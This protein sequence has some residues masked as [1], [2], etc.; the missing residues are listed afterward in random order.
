MNTDKIVPSTLQG[1]VLR[2]FKNGFD[3]S[4]EAVAGAGKTTMFLLLARANANIS[5]LLL[6]YNSKLRKETRDKA[7]LW[8]LN[9]IKVHTYHSF[10]KA[11][12]VASGYTDKS[13]RVAVDNDTPN[14]RPIKFDA[15]LLDEQQDCIEL[16][17]MLTCKVMRDNKSDPRVVVCGDPRQCIYQFKGADARFLTLG[18]N[19]YHRSDRN[20]IKCTLDLSHRIPNTH[21]QFVDMCMLDGRGEIRSNNKGPKP[22]YIVCNPLNVQH[23][24]LLIIQD[25]V[26]CGYGYEDI[27][28]LA[29]S[30]KKTSPV[31]LLENLLVSNL[32]PCYSP[33]NEDRE[34]SDT[35]MVNK[36][37]FS[38]FHQAK[39]RERKCV[40]V[41]GFDAYYFQFYARENDPRTCP[42]T[43]Y[44][45]ATRA[46][47]DM[48]LVQG[49]SAGPMKFLK[50]IEE[51]AEL[52]YYKVDP[53]MPS[54]PLNIQHRVA[55]KTVTDLLKYIS[56]DV[57]DRLV[58]SIEMI[59]VSAPEPNELYVPS[60]HTSKVPE[61][62]EEVSDINGCVATTLLE[63]RKDM[64]EPVKVVPAIFKGHVQTKIYSAFNSRFPEI[65]DR[66]KKVFIKWI[67]EDNTLPLEDIVFACTVFQ[68]HDYV[69]RVMQLTDF[70][71][72]D[73]ESA[74]DV[75][76]CLNLS[77]IG[78][79]AQYEFSVTISKP[80]GYQ[81]ELQGRYDIVSSTKLIEVKYV[82]ELQPVH[83]LQLIVYAFMYGED[84]GPEAASKISYDLLNTRTRECWSMKYDGPK[85]ANVMR[86]ILGKKNDISVVSDESFLATCQLTSFKKQSPT[87]DSICLII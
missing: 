7:N 56:D 53:L 39:G 51:Y 2:E 22:R 5:F 58:D 12:Y 34:P 23:M 64:G 32:I 18:K 50:N 54:I 6:T 80:L 31:A 3:I 25:W 71:W 28:V 46:L 43:M 10:C 44:V 62:V 75:L 21:A 4:I 59:Q 42:N 83:K 36:I 82:S 24:I 70:C 45:A 20:W 26:K 61:S 13:I 47:D 35:A 17:Y 85:L 37:S 14:N 65:Y 73:E 76:N 33:I 52:I 40:V 8:G 41:Y 63:L 11:F 57:L 30:L 69:S 79:D 84:K 78:E 81:Y 72:W 55:D 66:F 67:N 49:Q 27:M 60:I 77:D 86:E 29:P 9:N 48:I 38:T 68:N 15:I 19:I 87:R 16:Y 1:N 74:I